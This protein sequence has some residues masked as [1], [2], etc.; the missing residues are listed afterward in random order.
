MVKQQNKVP[1][2]SDVF[3][4][5]C[6]LNENKISYYMI[7]YTLLDFK[8]YLDK[9][10]EK[11]LSKS[12]YSTKCLVKCCNTFIFLLQKSILIFSY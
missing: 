8:D 6:K 5:Q 3:L 4:K 10:S 11:R 7:N 9:L 2:N 1:R 12:H